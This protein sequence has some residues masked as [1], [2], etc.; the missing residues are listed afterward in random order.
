[1]GGRL[2]QKSSGAWTATQPV[3]GP[4]SGTGLA[5]TYWDAAGNTTTTATDVARVGLT[6]QSQSS[7]RVYRST[8]AVFLLQDLVTQVAV[9]NNPTY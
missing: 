6:V 7:Q 5:F 8:G 2:Y 4:L 3:L 9:R 1:M